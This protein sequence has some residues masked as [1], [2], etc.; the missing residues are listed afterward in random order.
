MKIPNGLLNSDQ[1]RFMAEAV[2]KYGKDDEA[3]V[4]DITTRQN[5]QLRGLKVGGRAGERTARRRLPAGL[6]G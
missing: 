2:A 1:L 5:I 6:A 4:I 3:C